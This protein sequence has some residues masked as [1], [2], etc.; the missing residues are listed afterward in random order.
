MGE[1]YTLWSS[2]IPDFYFGNVPFIQLMNTGNGQ[3][4]P[5]HGGEIWV[6]MV[7]ILLIF[8]IYKL[9]RQRLKFKS[10]ETG[11]KRK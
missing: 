3:V 7:L 6:I 2:R 9:Q 5:I 4:K 8:L 10:V 1:N 11:L